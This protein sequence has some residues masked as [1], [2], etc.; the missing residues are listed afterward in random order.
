MAPSAGHEMVMAFRMQT[1]VSA[2]YDWQGGL[3]W[4]QMEHGDPE[5]ELVRA[6]VKRH[7]GG[8]ATLVRAAPALRAA[9]AVFQ[10]QEPALA[11]LSARLKEQF[12]P[13]NILNPGRIA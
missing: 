4:L 5:A 7:G 12:D 13:K 2:F 1:A 6:L 10:P 11:A 3:I 9:L 8:H